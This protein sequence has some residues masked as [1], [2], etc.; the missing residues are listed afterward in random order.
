MKAAVIS[1]Y[2]VVRL[3]LRA[4]VER[5]GCQVVLELPADEGAVGRLRRRQCELALLDAVT[6]SVQTREAICR[7]LETSVDPPHLLAVEWQGCRPA[8]LSRLRQLGLLGC[9]SLA[10]DPT[11]LTCALSAAGNGQSAFVVPGRNDGRSHVP[12]GRVGPE[13]LEQDEEILR[14]LANTPCGYAAVG[15][16]LGYSASTVRHRVEDLKNHFGLSTLYRLGIWA[17]RWG[18]VDQLRDCTG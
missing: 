11:P 10:S 18:I 5:S 6:T 7:S 12:D 3:G 14:A 2:L 15:Q 4:L 1:D 13:L 16:G 9:V 17:R 8:Q